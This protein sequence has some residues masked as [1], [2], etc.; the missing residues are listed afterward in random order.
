MVTM[1]QKRS[2]T[3]PP[4][5]E[6]RRQKKKKKK[7]TFSAGRGVHELRTMHGTPVECAVVM[8][9]ARAV[10]GGGEGSSFSSGEGGRVGGEG[11]GGGGGLAQ[12]ASCGLVGWPDS[13]TSGGRIAGVGRR[14]CRCRCRCVCRALACCVSSSLLSL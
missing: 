8:P 12:L 2:H 4:P 9:A 6:E 10:L 14:P 5:M 13:S 3:L 1:A 7:K 11:E